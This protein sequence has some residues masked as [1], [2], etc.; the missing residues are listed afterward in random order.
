MRALITGIT[1]Q[2][3]SYLAELLLEKGYEVFGLVRKTSSLDRIQ[4][5]TGKIRLIEGDLTDQDS[6]DAAVRTSQP[7]ELYN[8]AAQS[9]VAESWKEPELTVNVNGNGVVRLLDSIRKCS[10][11][12]KFLQ[13]S[14]SEMLSNDG[15]VPLT[16][17]AEVRTQNFYGF[18]K[19]I[20]HQSVIRYR[21]KHRL[22]ACSCICFSHESPRRGF[23]F[24]TRKV[25]W[26]VARIKVG[27][28]H[29]LKMGNLDA[30]R[31]WGYAGDTVRAMWMM[32]QQSQ[33]EDYVIAT[34]ELHS[35]RDLLQTAFSRVRLDWE[36]Y[37]EVDP[38]LFRPV[39][40]DNRLG[41]AT[42]ARTKLGW[43]PEVAFPQLIEMMVDSDLARLREQMA[44]S[45]VKAGV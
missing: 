37:V 1:G 12:T 14:S 22:F 44:V 26:N 23:E 13:A 28:E 15:E 34:G 18:G 19:S 45:Q 36:K 35:V 8:L 21:E 42:K 30:R 43:K 31:D 41:N 16:E 2:D 6:L 25:S 38:A 39:E 20:A 10:P 29:K 33:P 40:S 9:S 5:I 4:S 32:L 3:G 27:L 7:D 11:T 24:V 17:T